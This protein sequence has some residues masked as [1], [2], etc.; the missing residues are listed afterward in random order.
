MERLSDAFVALPGGYGTLDE[1]FEMVTWSQL[2]LMHKPI[3]LFNVEGYFDPLIAMVAHASREGFIAAE[4]A[5]LLR[6]SS[7]P[8]ALVDDLLQRA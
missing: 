7:D 1:L 4:H 5:A 2:G 6:A 3:A 8:R